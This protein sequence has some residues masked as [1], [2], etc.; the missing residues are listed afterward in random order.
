MWILKRYKWIILIISI[1]YIKG[2][3]L[4]LFIASNNGYSFGGVIIEKALIIAHLAILGILVFPSLM[5]KDKT[6]LKYLICIDIIYTI[7]IILD[8]WVYRG[9]GQVLELRFLFFNEGFNTLNRG[10]INPSFK[11]II[12]LIDIVVFI[13]LYKK[14][15][16][17]FTCKRKIKLSLILMS[18]SLVIISSYHYMFD[19]KKISNGKIR[20][21]QDEWEG[22]WNAYTRVLYRSPIGHHIYEGYKTVNKIV[23]KTNEKEIKEIEDWL[24]WNNEDLDDNEYKSIAKGKNVIFLQIES[25]ENFVINSKV[26]NQE[27]TPNLNRLTK[28]GLYFKNIHE[29]NNA[30]NSIDMDMMA[31]TGVLPLGDVIT[32]LEY[33]EVKYNSLPRLL[34]KEGYNTI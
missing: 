23:K 20:F 16:K 4:T 25:L 3:L 24:L 5:F 27:I 12:F 11:D 22:S 19:I 10:V 21:I 2:I 13:F 1:L 34:N 15:I 9:T 14:S 29:Q 7:F 28:E 6:S 33:P 18:I 30:G 17:N 32:Y 8:L 31:A 26:Y